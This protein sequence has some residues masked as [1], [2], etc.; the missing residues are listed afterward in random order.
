MREEAAR[1][2][3][4]TDHRRSCHERADVLETQRTDLA[5]CLDVL[6]AEILAGRRRFR[7]YRQFKMYND[8][9]MNPVLRSARRT[10]ESPGG[11]RE[12]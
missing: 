12:G 2:D 8:P 6:F 10:E 9:E 11:E 1:D 5:G 3:A 4:E 7:R